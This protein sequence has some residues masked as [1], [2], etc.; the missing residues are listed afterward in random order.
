MG[1]P[2]NSNY[3]FH[4]VKYNEKTTPQ[5]R[6][7]MNAKVGFLIG[8]I[9]EREMRIVKTLKD[10]DISREQYLELQAEY[11][12]DQAKGIQR[13]AYSN[14]SNAPAGGSRNG[15]EKDKGELSERVITAGV[16]AS[17][18]AEAA[19]ISSERDEVKK[20]KLILRNLT[21][22][23]FGKD[24]RDGQVIEIQATHTLSDDELEY[25][26]F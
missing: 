20:M 13:Q 21:D 9:E 19:N 7:K 18:Q 14:Y 25:L 8:K 5:V 22:N 11:L 6:E 4:A 24:P 3:M 2:R 16:L 10:N 23:V 1:A 15:G 26:A 12:R 17:L